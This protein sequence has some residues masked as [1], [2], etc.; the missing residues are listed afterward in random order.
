M[1]ILIAFKKNI[2]FYLNFTKRF[3]HLLLMFRFSYLHRH[4]INFEDCFLLTKAKLIVKLL[5]KTLLFPCL[6]KVGARKRQSSAILK[7]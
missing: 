4:S 6:I 1:L 2:G 7:R 3:H 5:F